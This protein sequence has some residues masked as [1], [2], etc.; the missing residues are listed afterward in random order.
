[1]SVEVKIGNE[2]WA[3]D[4]FV[5]S[6]VHWRNRAE[7]AERERDEAKAE[8]SIEAALHD[9]TRKERDRLMA[10]ACLAGHRR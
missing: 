3:I 6:F 1:M 2:A 4:D 7:K 10:G 5:T 8:L 9:D